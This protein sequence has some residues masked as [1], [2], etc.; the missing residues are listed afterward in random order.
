M[1]RRQQQ[2]QLLLYAACH[3]VALVVDVVLLDVVFRYGYDARV[4]VLLGPFTVV[5]ERGGAAS[6]GSDRRQRRCGR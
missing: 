2:V 4:V 5:Y 1:R 3:L 6:V